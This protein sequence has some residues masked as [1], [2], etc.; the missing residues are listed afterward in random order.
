MA[1][2]GGAISDFDTTSVAH[3]GSVFEFRGWSRP[4]QC[5]HFL[6]NQTQQSISRAGFH[7]EPKEHQDLEK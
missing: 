1:L 6:S 5:T 7:Q 2:H 4:V 3:I